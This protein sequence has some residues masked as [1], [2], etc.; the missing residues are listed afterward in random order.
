MS[1]AVSDMMKVCP[2]EK[3]AYKILGVLKENNVE[4]KIVWVSGYPIEIKGKQYTQ[5]D[6][7]NILGIGD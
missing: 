3:S 7:K 6:L 2:E 4:A 1:D 5:K